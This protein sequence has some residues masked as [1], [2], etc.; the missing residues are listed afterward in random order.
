MSHIFTILVLSSQGTQNSWEDSNL[1][2]YKTLL[3]WNQN[4]IGM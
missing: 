1:I 4:S 3:L 2:P